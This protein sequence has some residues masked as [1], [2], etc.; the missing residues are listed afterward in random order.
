MAR[1][2][3]AMSDNSGRLAAEAGKK[4]NIG[5]LSRENKENAQKPAAPVIINNNSSTGGNTA[6]PPVSMPRGG[7]RPSESAME[8]Y[9]NRTS[10]FW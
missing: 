4:H 9:A 6:A 1:Q 2:M 8:K 7:V 5:D 10:H 3:Q